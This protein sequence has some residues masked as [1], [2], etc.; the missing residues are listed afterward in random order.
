[1]KPGDIMERALTALERLRGDP[2]VIHAEITGSMRRGKPVVGDLDLLIVTRDPMAFL[3]DD[4]PEGT[5]KPN[6]RA[7]SRENVADIFVAT[8]QTY[9]ATLVFS[10]GP[11][12][13]NRKLR[14]R[15]AA[16]GLLYDFRSPAHGNFEDVFA[17]HGQFVGLYRLDGTLVPT[18]TEEAFFRLLDVPY[19]PP[20]HREWLAERL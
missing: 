13:I 9:G 4:L 11:R 5:F 2:R 16:R 20:P 17:E 10:T 7:W 8:P 1:M 3:G 19:V 14:P 15:A 18:P 6:T 12:L